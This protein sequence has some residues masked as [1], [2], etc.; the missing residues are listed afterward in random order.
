MCSWDNSTLLKLTSD[1]A[2]SLSLPPPPPPP[3]PPGSKNSDHRLARS[4]A[5]DLA[6]ML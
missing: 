3:S 2:L 4:P 5:L 6:Y 1:Q